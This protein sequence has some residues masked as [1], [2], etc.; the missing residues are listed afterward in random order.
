MADR[1]GDDA[2]SSTFVLGFILGAAI[3]AGAGLPRGRPWKRRPEPWMP[4]YQRGG[5]AAG[6]P[7]SKR[8]PSR[9]TSCVTRSLEVRCLVNKSAGFSSPRTFFTV[10]LPARAACCTHKL[11]VSI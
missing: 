9:P 4:V 8:H 2:G 5:A 6:R 7:A 3:G 11:W 1:N 10:I